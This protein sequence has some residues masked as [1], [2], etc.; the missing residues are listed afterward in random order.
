MEDK[1]DF[2]LWIH[3]LEMK[4]RVNSLTDYSFKDMEKRTTMQKKR[5]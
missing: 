5:H 2:H 4:V 1:I 3:S